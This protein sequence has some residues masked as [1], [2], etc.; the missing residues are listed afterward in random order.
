MLLSTVS[1]PGLTALYCILQNHA[2]ESQNDTHTKILT[3]TT[4]DNPGLEKQCQK[5]RDGDSV[6]YLQL[7]GLIGVGGQHKK[8]QESA[9]RGSFLLYSSNI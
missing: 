4:T 3:S 1:S 5:L 2:G 7:C 6:R 8:P 9:T